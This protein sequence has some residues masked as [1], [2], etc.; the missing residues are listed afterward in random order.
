MC[1]ADQRR[2]QWTPPQARMTRVGRTVAYLSL[3]GLFRNQSALI[4]WSRLPQCSSE[5]IR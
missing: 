2:W 4:S 3:W 5:R 1:L